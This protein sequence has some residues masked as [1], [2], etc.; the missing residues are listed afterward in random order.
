METM[1]QRVANDEIEID[2]VELFHVLL[3]KAVVI[4]LV[5]VVGAGAMFAYTKFLVTPQYTAKSSLFIL[6]KTTSV[7]SLADIQ[8]S[9]YLTADFQ[10][11]ATSRPVIEEVIDTLELDYT[12]E[13]LVAILTV[14]NPADSR[15]LELII[16]HPNPEKAAEIAN[17]MADVVADRVAS[18]MVTDKPTNVERAVV[19]KNPSSPNTMMNTAIGGLAGLVLAV[20]VII[21]RH[22]MDDTIKTEEDVAKYLGTGVLAMFPVESSSMSSGKSSGSKGG[23]AKVAKRTSSTQGARNA[24]RTKGNTAVKVEKEGE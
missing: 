19:A 5:A 10:V 2:L 6:S 4:I 24:T 22:L 16:E 7:T 17:E 9:N 23:G 12:Y 8:L 1:N 20:G 3:R 21:V 14:N 15:V 11:L 18:V 13:E